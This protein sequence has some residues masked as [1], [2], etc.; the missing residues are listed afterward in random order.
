MVKEFEDETFPRYALVL[1]TMLG[2]RNSHC[3]EEAVSVAASFATTLDT[4]ESFLDLLFVGPKAIT[5]SAGGHGSAREVEKMLEILARVEPA[6]DESGLGLLRKELGLRCAELS[7]CILVLLDWDA[8]R[9]DLADELRRRGVETL[10]LVVVE[11]EQTPEPGVCFL[12]AGK[13]QE[14]LWNLRF[15]A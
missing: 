5:V 10:A 3:F 15:R 9:R 4:K 7:A 14:R 12:K 2:R 11:G 8:P 1:D 13:V 6:Y